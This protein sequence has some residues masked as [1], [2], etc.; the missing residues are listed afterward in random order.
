MAGWWWV[1][2]Q[3]LRYNWLAGSSTRQ[4]VF[5]RHY[6]PDD[7]TVSYLINTDHHEWKTQLIEHMFLP[8]E[9]SS[10]LGM[11]LSSHACLDTVIWPHTTNGRYSVRS[12]YRFLMERANWDWPNHSNMES[13]SNLWKNIWSLKVIPRVKLFLW[14]ACLEAL[15]TKANLFNRHLVTS[16]LCDEYHREACDECHWE[17]EDI[18]HVI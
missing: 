12:A 5:L 9:A 15:P 18:M 11:P 4:I 10:I 16:L 8:H 17:A 2:N 6:F 13:E 1:Q 7:A 3:D 14:R